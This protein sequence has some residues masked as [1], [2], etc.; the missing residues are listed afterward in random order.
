MFSALLAVVSLSLSVA[1]VEVQSSNPA[2]FNA[3]IQGCMAV[4][5][6]ADGEP[7]IIHNCNT[8]NTA[9]Q[10]W[11][12]T[13]DVRTPVGPQQ[14]KIFGDKCID[15]KDGVNADGT[16]LQIWSCISGSKNQQ[17]IA[18][19]TENTF[20]WS[21]T[22]KCIDLSDGKITDDNV[23]Q[24]W[25]CTDNSANQNWAG[26]PNPDTEQRGDEIASTISC[27]HIIPC[28]LLPTPN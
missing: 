23:L 24:I 5:D 6:N 21:G 19:P 8:E 1:A 20:Q 3:G 14:I 26:A 25:T 9:N 16:K 2:F 22:D 17:W 12:V 10:D 18:Q 11:D 15:V 28:C 27:T 4:A 7:L 13:F